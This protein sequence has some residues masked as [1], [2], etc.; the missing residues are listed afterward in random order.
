[1]IRGIRTS[2]VAVLAVL[3]AMA[4]QSVAQEAGKGLE[5]VV[6]TAQKRSESIN[7]VPMSITAISGDQLQALGVSDMSQLAKTVPGFAYADSSYGTPIYFIRGIGFFDTSLASKPTVGVYVDEVPLAF[8]A[9]TL[10]AVFDLERVE[11]LKGPQGTLF[12][13]NATGGAIN[14]IAA[15]PTDTFAAGFDAGAGNFGSYD[16]GGFVSGPLTDTLRARVA[17]KHSQSDGWQKS[18][19]RP[20]D[21]LG[22]RDFTQARMILDWRPLD[23]LTLSLNINGFIDKSETQAPQFVQTFQQT[24]GAFL[25]PR[26]PTY[27]RASNDARQADWGYHS[28]YDLDRDNTLW[29]STLRADYEITDSVTLT[30]LTSYS[31]FDQ[32]FGQDGDGTALT[33]A[34]LYIVGQVESFTQELRVAGTMDKG[35]WVVGVNYSRDKAFEQD[36][37]RL[38]ESSSGHAFDRLGLP[39]TEVVPQVGTTT[40]ESAAVFANATYELVQGLNLQ[41]GARYTDTDIDFEG[42]SLNAG[43]QTFARGFSASLGY[44][45]IIPVGECVTFSTDTPPVPQM[46]VDSKSESNVSWRTGLDWNVTADTLLYANISRGYKAGGYPTLPGTNAPQYAPVDQE[47][48]TAYEVGVKSTLLARTLQMNGAVFYNDYT[49]KQLKGRTVVPVFGP[50][51]ALVN[52][53]KSKV[54]GAEL[55]VDWAPIAGLRLSSGVTYLDTE[56]T[57]GSPGGNYTVF[58]GSV[59]TNLKGQAF[60]Y[61]SKWQV[62]ADGE[63][64]FGVNSTLDGFVGVGANYRSETNGDFLP[65]PRLD[66]DAYTLIDVRLGVASSDEKWRATL[67]GRNITDEYYWFTANRRT[68]SVI[69]YA[70]MPRTYGISFSYR[71]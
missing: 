20:G 59:R 51:E 60:P 40:F 2:H 25:D 28:E 45:G 16:V 57:E 66:I 62:S 70:G 63:Y 4:H 12:G 53:P 54:Q 38:S 52:I 33:I 56:V 19:T 32:E 7:S 47:K 9:L 6:V 24:P 68:D 64:S 48:I 31:D 65:D 49:D 30:S 22:A 67:Y 34:D 43:N 58:G 41:L 15:K 50:L 18:S 13:Q 44:T 55:Q 69:R 42:C 5:E 37:Q 27:P 61:A 3:Q 46:V 36:D 21:T 10:G 23:A 11:V 8:P 71:Y 14:Y 1:M 35:N 39:P 17:V 26:L 29:Q